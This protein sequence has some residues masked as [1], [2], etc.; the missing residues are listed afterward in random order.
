MAS[1]QTLSD[2]PDGIRQ[3][4]VDALAPDE[5]FVVAVREEKLLARFNPF[6]IVTDRRL[7]R[8]RKRWLGFSD[9]LSD[10]VFER[11]SHVGWRESN[12]GRTGKL[13]LT[14]PEYERTLSFLGGDG[15]V[16]ADAIRAQRA[17]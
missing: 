15:R 13:E 10:T 16:L 5:E 2:L 12:F 6:W 7:I 1:Y 3:R 9:V 8:Y 4:V 17:R 11:L 14:A